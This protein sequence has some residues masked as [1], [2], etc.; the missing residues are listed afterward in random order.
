M[1]VIIIKS[2]IFI[3]T[4]IYFLIYF[5][6]SVNEITT[7]FTEIE[8]RSLN[9][10]SGLWHFIRGFTKAE[11]SSRLRVHKMTKYMKYKKALEEFKP[12][13]RIFMFYSRLSVYRNR[14]SKLTCLL[15]KERQKQTDRKTVKHH[16]NTTEQ[17]TAH[18]KL[19]ILLD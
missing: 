6:R 10:D 4:S 19:K 3:S 11:I 17:L 9:K 12:L 2:V 18:I 7:E 16:T 5:C 1:I 8:P 15:V 14:R 13:P